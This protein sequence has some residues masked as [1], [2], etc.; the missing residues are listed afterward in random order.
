MYGSE[1]TDLIVKYYDES[2]GISGEEE[3]EWYLARARA[4]GGPMLDLACGTGRLALRLAQAGFEVSGI[5]DS[6]GMLNVFNEKLKTVS[7]KIRQRVNISKH[8]MSDF[9]L[10]KQFNTILCCD[11]FFHNL[12]VAEEMACLDCVR[13]HLAP[14]GRF[15][16]NLPNP[17][18]EFI[19]KSAH[20]AGKE[21]TERGRYALKDTSDM[22]QV[23]Q[24]QAGNTFDQL[25]ITTLRVTR[26]DLEG[27]VVER[28]ETSWSTRY[29]FRYEAI[30]LLY[31]CGFDVEALV[32]DYSDGPVTE[33]GQLIFQALLSA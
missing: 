6:A 17:T 16:F 13:R 12:T 29:L 3:V 10:G 9:N 14:G 24:S 28:S 2:F 4:F 21:F 33:K 7:L 8:K 30:H 23:E 15:V 25:I 11:A 32:G 1:E 27:R 20:S 5:D 18:C 22:L 31:R 19:L 26:I